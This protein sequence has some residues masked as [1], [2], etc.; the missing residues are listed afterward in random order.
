MARCSTKWRSGIVKCL[1]EHGAN[2]SASDI[3]ERT[4]LHSAAGNGHQETVKWLVE[5]GAVLSAS[6][7]FKVE[8]VK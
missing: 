3:F 1:V 8:V 6:S 4:P 7:K 2:I 5:H